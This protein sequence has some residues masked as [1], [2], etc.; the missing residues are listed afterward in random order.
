MKNGFDYMSETAYK[1]EDQLTPIWVGGIAYDESVMFLGTNDVVPLLYNATEI[2]SVTSYD[3][4]K[5]FKVGADYQLV[6][7][8]LVMPEGSEMTYV[9][10]EEYWSD[11][12]YGMLTLRD[13][14]EAH[15]LS[16]PG[17]TMTRYQVLVTYRHNDVLPVSIPDCSEQL[18][19]VINKLENGEDV[20]FFFYGDS[21]TEGWESSLRCK[22]EP[23]VPS[24]SALFTQYVAHRY[25]YKVKY[26]AT[27]AEGTFNYPIE[28]DCYGDRGTIYYINT[29]ISGWTVEKSYEKYE[30]HVKP[31]TDEYGCDLFFYAH[32]MNNASTDMGDFSIGVKKVIN[33]LHEIIPD[34]KFVIVSSMLPN[35]EDTRGMRNVPK[36]ESVLKDVVCELERSGIPAVLSP[37]QSVHKHICEVK[38]YRDHSGNNNNHP[39]D[40]TH[41]VYAQ[42][43]L[44][45]VFGY[46]E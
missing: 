14:V 35:N 16:G 42:I 19:S 23:K 40:Y 28:Q 1:Y 43:A 15:T 31:Y 8:K 32:G 37:V 9:P 36:Q 39:N 21:I 38:R 25:G 7:G 24:W 18:T 33:T 46:A 12:W 41:R 29:A 44:Q 26:V 27:T 5:T 30:T 10:E 13:G 22:L 45:T 11:G 6:D 34:A 4:S 20:T 17:D 3:K 2:I